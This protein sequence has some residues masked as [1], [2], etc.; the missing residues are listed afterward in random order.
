MSAIDF[1]SPVPADGTA[2]YA[3]GWRLI[4]CMRSAAAA[5]S[6]NQQERPKGTGTVRSFAILHGFDHRS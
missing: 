3:H 5:R 4:S 6:G 1:P 2:R